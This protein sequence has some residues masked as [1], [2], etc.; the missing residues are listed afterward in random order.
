MVM[1]PVMSVSW[2]WRQWCHWHVK[3]VQWVCQSCESLWET[4]SVHVLTPQVVHW[5]TH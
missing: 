3:Y 2:L 5:V 4:I 1:M